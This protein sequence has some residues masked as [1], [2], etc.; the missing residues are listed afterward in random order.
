M[1]ELTGKQK[2]VLRGL[3]QQLD[4]AVIVG[5]AGLTAGVVA[6]VAEALAR[7][8]LVKVRLPAGPAPGRKALA[9]ELAGAVAAS[10][11]GVVGRTM[12][13]YRPNEDLPAEQRIE[14]PGR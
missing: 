11:L 14:L 8:E 3:G 13:L 12:L 10:G 9:A 6:A 4:P 2:H 7:R 1:H 5:K